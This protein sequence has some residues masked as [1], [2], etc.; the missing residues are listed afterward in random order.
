MEPA[1]RRAADRDAVAA[2]RP[3]RRA[4]GRAFRR[5][6]AVVFLMAVFVAAV[7]VAVVIATGTSSTVVQFRKVVAS[8]AQSAINDVHNLINQYTK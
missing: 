4:R 8:D 3:P 1:R 6:L 2:E 5:F 7:V